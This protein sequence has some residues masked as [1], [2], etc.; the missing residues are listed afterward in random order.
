MILLSAQTLMLMGCP[1]ID[2]ESENI[3]IVNRSDK[4]ICFQVNSLTYP[5]ANEDTLLLGQFP[6]FGIKPE[7][8]I[9][10]MQVQIQIGGGNCIDVVF[11][12]SL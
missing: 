6:V 3:K 8:T 2:S 11:C 1:M 7:H 12:K 10:V 9:Y 4:E 5:F